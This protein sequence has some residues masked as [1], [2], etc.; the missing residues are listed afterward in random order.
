MGSTPHAHAMANV[1]DPHE[2]G[3]VAMVGVFIDTFVVLTITALVVI[4]TLYAGNGV[5]A[6]G[7]A[8]GIDKTNMAQIA[9]GEI[10]GTKA[11]NI[12][13]AISLFFFAFTTILGWNFFGKINMVYLFGKK[14]VKIYSVIAVAFIFTGS[15]LS[16]D[17]V[18]ELT[19]MFNQLMVIPNVM[20]LIALSRMITAPRKKAENTAESHEKEKT[21]SK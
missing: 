19:D 21:L 5:L 14:S 8:D 4:S 16:N 7:A 18:W 17:L 1:K 11:G 20:A 12:F 10:F 9:F 15:V 3:V 6:S 2:Q 13:V